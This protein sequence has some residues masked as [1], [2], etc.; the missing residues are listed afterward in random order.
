MT[1]HLANSTGLVNRSPKPKNAFTLIE[2]LFVI[3]IIA[4]L[5][6]L[7]LPAVR[8]A[9]PA[10]RRSQCKNNLRQIALALRN[11]AEEYNAF[12]PAYTVDAKGKRLHS[13]RTLI[14]PY[15][16]QK[17]LYDRIDLSKAWDDPANAAAFET[18]VSVYHCP[19]ANCPANHTTYLAV[20]APGSCIHPTRSR[21]LSEV[22]DGSRETLMVIEVNAGQSVH[23]MAPT[24]A[25]EKLL[26]G[27]GPNTEL[28]HAN[29]WHA[30]FTDGSVRFLTADL[31]AAKR[32]ALISGEGKKTLEPKPAG[33]AGSR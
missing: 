17:K 29:G 20:V 15:L 24:D 11:Y 3:A 25:D 12:P 5:V 18:G 30:A 9:G 4:I 33:R 7:M 21:R 31:P 10:A 8:T 28:P 26:L 2:L 6:A 22:T 23:W 32:R 16:E 13:W 27:F 14:L 19:E 1:N